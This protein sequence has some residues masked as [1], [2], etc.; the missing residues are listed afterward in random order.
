MDGMLYDEILRCLPKRPYNERGCWVNCDG[1][2][3]CPSPETANVIA[4]FFEAAGMDIMCTSYCDDSD[5]GLSYGWYA[6]YVDGG[7]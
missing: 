5:M 4:D 2:I 7:R 3:M 1:W 6:V